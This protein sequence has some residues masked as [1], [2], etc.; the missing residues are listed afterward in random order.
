MARQI[1]ARTG[2]VF[3][4]F[5]RHRTLANLLLVIMLAAGLLAMPNMRAQFF[6][7]VIVDEIDVS[8]RWDGAGSADVG[9]WIHRYLQRASAGMCTF[10]SATGTLNGHSRR[11]FRCQC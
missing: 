9:A 11:S 3:S 7:D 4:Y 10:D 6:P 8:V 2:G 5:T 1:S